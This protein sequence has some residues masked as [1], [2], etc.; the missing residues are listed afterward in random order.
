MGLDDLVEDFA[1]DVVHLHNLMNPAVLEWAA[2]RPNALLTVQDH[3]FFCPTRG[4]WTLAGEVCRRPMM[5]EVCASCFEDEAYFRGVHALTERRLLAARRLPLTVLSRY[6]REELVAAGAP[7]PT[8]ARR[9]AVRPSPRPRGGPERPAVR[10]LRG[11]ARRGEGRARRG[12]GVAPRRASTCRSCSPERGRSARSSRRRRLGAR[13][14]S[15]RCPAGWIAIGSPGSTPGPRAAAAVALAG[16]LRHRGPRGAEL[17]RAGRGLGVRRRRR[18]APGPGSRPLGR[19][20]GSGARPARCRDRRVRC[21]RAS[22]ATRRSADSSRSTRGSRRAADAGGRRT[23]NRQRAAERAGV[24]SGER[25]RGTRGAGATQATG[26]GL[27]ASG[28]SLRRSSGEVR[29][30]A[31]QRPP[32]RSALLGRFHLGGRDPLLAVLLGDRAGDDGRL[33][34]VADVAERFETSFFSM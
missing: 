6:M 18:V 28:D 8:R 19:R 32:E 23:G 5:R 1:P 13:G 15:S 11:P 25:A 9:A 34:V 26:N 27:R 14:R 24:H 29:G 30:G 17:R 20:R 16:A 4:K 22:I 33:L 31:N 3:R 10:A 2:S 7:P 21:R 12:R